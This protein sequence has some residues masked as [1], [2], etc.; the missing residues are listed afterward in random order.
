LEEINFQTSLF[1]T[2]LSH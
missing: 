1:T 2:L